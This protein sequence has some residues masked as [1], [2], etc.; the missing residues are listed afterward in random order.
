[1]KFKDIKETPHKHLWTYR[2]GEAKCSCGLYLQPDGSI[3]KDYSG[4]KVVEKPKK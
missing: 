3:T 1:M 2:G 4:K